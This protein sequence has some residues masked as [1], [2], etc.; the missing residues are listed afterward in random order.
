MDKEIRRTRL[1][2]ADTLHQVI[3][4]RIGRRKIVD[5]FS[6]RK[7]LKSEVV[8]IEEL[9]ASSSHMEVSGIRV[10]IAIGLVKR[11]GVGSAEITVRVGVVSLGHIKMIKKVSK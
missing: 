2:T 6:D 10:R 11:H 5:N 9:K 8:S 7:I 3:E 1:D 4:R